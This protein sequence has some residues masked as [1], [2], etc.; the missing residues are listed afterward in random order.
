LANA[1]VLLMPVVAHAR[2]LVHTAGV[3]VVHLLIK[4]LLT[5]FAQLL[6][7]VGDLVS[8]LTIF[9]PQVIELAIQSI[10]L[11]LAVL[12]FLSQFVFDCRELLPQ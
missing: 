11:G 6:I 12:L 9:G 4:L 2:A 1:R 7:V 3:V 5:E 8:Q 10:D